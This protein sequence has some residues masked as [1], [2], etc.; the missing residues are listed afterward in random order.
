MKYGSD[1]EFLDK[2]RN[3]DFSAESANYEKNLEDLKT[4]LIYKENLD[5]KK[6]FKMPFAVAA[7]LAVTLSLTVVG[8]AATAWRYLDT[9][10]IE[11]EEYVHNFTVKE[12]ED[13]NYLIWSTE[14]DPD[15]TGPIVADVDGEE[16]V[17]L[18]AHHY[19]DLDEAIARL[20]A[21]LGTTKMPANIPDGFTF[22]QATY[23]ANVTAL[24]ISYKYGEQ[25]L[26]VRI[27]YYPEEWGIPVWSGTFELVEVNGFSGKTGGGS[28]WVQVGDV[29]YMFDGYNSDLDYD[30]L[31][32]IA[33][34]LQ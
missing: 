27:S 11:G 12:S 7:A 31:I 33:E 2:C 9:R 20:E 23:H 28:L 30:Q 4:N 5:M 32:A 18:D 14:I 21:T 22:E 34:S 6:S 24:N 8:L 15:A 13:G 3:I 16:V 26:D 17:L 29:S 10:I 19:D 1:N 25:E